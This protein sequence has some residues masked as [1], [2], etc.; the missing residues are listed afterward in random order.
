M[1]KVYYIFKKNDINLH[2]QIH[3]H[4]RGERKRERDCFKIKKSS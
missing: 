3:T 4:R 2:T 1:V